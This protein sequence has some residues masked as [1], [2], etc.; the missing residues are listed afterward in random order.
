[1]GRNSLKVMCWISAPT[2]RRPSWNSRSSSHW[3]LISA[4]SRTIRLCSLNQTVCMAANWGCSLTRPSPNQYSRWGWLQKKSWLETW[5]P[6][7]VNVAKQSIITAAPAVPTWSQLGPNLV[8]ATQIR[9]WLI[10]H[11]WRQLICSVRNQSAVGDLDAGRKHLRC[12]GSRS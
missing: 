10:Q 12:I 7:P 5:F 8:T 11:L 3:G 9:S 6:N 4:S 1:M 2:M